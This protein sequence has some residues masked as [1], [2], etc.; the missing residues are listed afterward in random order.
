M[1]ELKSLLASLVALEQQATAAAADF[2][3]RIQAIKDQA[4]KAALAAGVTPGEP[5]SADG[6]QTVFTIDS[7]GRFRRKSV[8]R[9]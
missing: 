2:A 7:T 3:A 5:H 9:I 8:R 4:G 6:G 1:D